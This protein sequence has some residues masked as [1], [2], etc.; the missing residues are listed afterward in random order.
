M[1]VAPVVSAALVLSA[2]ELGDAVPIDAVPVDSV[3]SFTT[4]SRWIHAKSASEHARAPVHHFTR[5]AFVRGIRD[6]GYKSNPNALAELV[7]NSV[8]AGSDR[9]EVF[10]GYDGGK[11]DK[12]PNQIAVLD[13]G[14]GMEP[15]MIRAAVTWGGTHR[16]GDRT[17][18]GR[19]GYGLPSACVKGTVNTSRGPMSWRPAA[20][21]RDPLWCSRRP[22][23]PRPIRRST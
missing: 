2:P 5:D 4:A 12:K 9:V 19:Y 10:F 7:D 18:F 11:S 21:G 8:Q 3:G 23:R 13:N 6:L 1:A 16:E 15:D 14:H 20:R 17:G 22:D